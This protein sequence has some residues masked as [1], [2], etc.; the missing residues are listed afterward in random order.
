MATYTVASGGVFTNTQTGIRRSFPTG[1][2]IKLETA[3]LYGMPGASLPA[4]ESPFGTSEE[5][6]I[7][8][9][10]QAAAAAATEVTSIAELT[11]VAITSP[12]EGDVLTYETDTWVNAQPAGV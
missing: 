11:D 12:Q 7:T 2:V 3:V 10:A 4:A 9:L 5:A 8:A 1:S 6:R